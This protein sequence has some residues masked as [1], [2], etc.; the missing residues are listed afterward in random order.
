M[1]AIDWLSKLLALLLLLLLPLLFADVGKPYRAAKSVDAVLLW[2]F[3][4]NRFSWWWWW[5]WWCKWSSIKPKMPKFGLSSSI[6]LLLLP[7]PLLP[8]LDPLPPL[9]AVVVVE[10]L[11]WFWWWWWK[12]NCLEKMA[13]NMLN[14][15]SDIECGWWWWWLLWW[16]WWLWL[17]PWWSKLAPLPPLE[18]L[19]PPPLLAAMVLLLLL[20]WLLLE[21][22]GVGVFRGSGGV[23][24]VPE[25]VEL[26]VPLQELL[27]YSILK[28]VKNYDAY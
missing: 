4:F 13:G 9:F 18:P 20:L 6:S 16:W 26:P 8:P 17:W 2:S 15:C 10:W 25:L 28:P 14:C 12:F 23:D 1:P 3:L 22:P 19:P 7:P 24:R 27:L 21:L 5:W 11:W